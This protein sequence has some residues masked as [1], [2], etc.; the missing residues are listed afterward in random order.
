M[1]P[2]DT[3]TSRP[4]W[5]EQAIVIFWAEINEK[6]YPELQRLQ[7]SLNGVKLT[8]GQAVKA[9][10]QGLKKGYPDLFLP[11]VRGGYC[12]LF[13]EMK[14]RK[15]GRLSKEQREMLAYLNHEGYY[16]V[17]AK[18]SDVAI[19]TLTDYLEANI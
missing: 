19:K 1:K 12:G 4:E 7:G 9:K 16:A 14:K 18:G 8:V 13:I 10:K 17:E 2:T 11:V 6:R 15:G 5:Q 3:I